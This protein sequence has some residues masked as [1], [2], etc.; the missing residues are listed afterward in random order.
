M[1]GSNVMSG[2]DADELARRVHAINERGR[3]VLNAA[4]SEEKYLFTLPQWPWRVAVASVPR[5]G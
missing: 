5:F 3:Y 2:L 1:A 4:Q